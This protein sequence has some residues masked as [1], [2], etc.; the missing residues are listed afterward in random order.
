MGSASDHFVRG[1]KHFM[2]DGIPK[3]L[4]TLDLL[5]FEGLTALDLS[6]LQINKPSQE[7]NEDQRHR[8]SLTPESSLGQCP[9]TSLVTPG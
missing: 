7:Q 5:I 1:H 2:P 4:G 3:R 6:D 9:E 8:K